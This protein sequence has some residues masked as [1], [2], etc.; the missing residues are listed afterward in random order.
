MLA[1]IGALLLATTDGTTLDLP[2]TTYTIDGKSH[3]LYW[4]VDDHPT[5]NTND[6]LDFFKQQNIKA[7]FFIVGYNLQAHNRYPTYGPAKRAYNSVVRIKTDGHTIGNHSLSHSDFCGSVPFPDWKVKY[8]VSTTQAL[9]K[10]A[11]GLNVVHWRPP[12]GKICGSVYKAV[13]QVGL[14]SWLWDI[15]DYKVRVERMWY[16]LKSRIANG[17]TS[18]ILLFHTDIQKLKSFFKFVKP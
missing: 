16:L 8:E 15:G 2:S 12:H 13:K 4:T 5:T 11:T 7:T 3:T 1:I 9:L 18:T 17:E 10:Q 14:K 6:F